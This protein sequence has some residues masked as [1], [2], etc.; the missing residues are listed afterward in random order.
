MERIQNR[1]GFAN[2]LFVSSCGRSGGLALIWTRETDLEIKSFSNHHIDAVVTE[3]NSNYKWRITGFYGHPQ[4]HLRQFSW[5][6]FAYLKNQ[7][8]LPWICFGN[9]N[10]ILSMKEK[11][12]EL[13]RS[14]G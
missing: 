3:A 5:D 10:E 1:I 14:Q 13:L 2:G 12:S 4:A 9:F 7:Y 8:Q 11:S 6:L